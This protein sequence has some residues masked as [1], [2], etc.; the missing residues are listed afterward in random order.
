MK[1][2]KGQTV[3]AVLA[4]TVKPDQPMPMIT[5]CELVGI[6]RSSIC[7]HLT[8]MEMDKRIK[9]YTTQRGMVRVW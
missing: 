1:R 2:R 4:V 7:R 6:S 8:Q 3:R 5:L 9:G